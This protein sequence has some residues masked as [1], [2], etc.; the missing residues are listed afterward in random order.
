MGRRLHA[1]RQQLPTAD[2]LYGP[3]SSPITQPSDVE[4]CRVLWM[5]PCQHIRF[6]G[7]VARMGRRSLAQDTAEFLAQAFGAVPFSLHEA[8]A[9]GL[10]RDRL[11]R[12]VRA[13]SV[14]RLSSGVFLVESKSVGATGE[15]AWE[16]HAR[17]STTRARGAA[18][19]LPRCAVSA[20]TAAL[21]QGLP[22]P[23]SGVELGHVTDPSSRSGL[24]RGVHVHSAALPQHHVRVL[25]GL[26]VT[27]PART[28]IDIAR[29]TSLPEALICMDAVLRRFI[30]L[31]R[32]D[33]LPLRMAVHDPDLIDAARARV[34]EVLK[35]MH[36]WPGT[37]TAREALELADPGA[38]SALES[39]SR[40]VL[41]KRGVPQPECGY[42]IEGADGRTYW[43]DMAWRKGRVIGECDGLVKYAEAGAL[44][45]E[46][47]RQEAIENAGSRV[48]RWTRHEVVRSP[49]RLAERVL[50]ALDTRT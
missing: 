44:Y 10:P 31:A 37:R 22:V 19:A 43:A 12:A 21:V 39:E 9:A 3:S 42:P 35:D 4:H 29:M 7:T 48:I 47:R 11:Y 27:T 25:D 20:T 14:R 41:L 6:R 13:G 2:L 45:E 8:T 24:R 49:D 33:G 46:K 23:L 28:A 36:G 32:D 17:H 18:L 34:A 50:R 15:A 38:E 40:G 1:A 30:D 5:T 16:A 26:R